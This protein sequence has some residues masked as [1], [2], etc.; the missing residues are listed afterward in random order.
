MKNLLL[1]F[2]V[3]F[4][5]SLFSQK[6]QTTPL[7][8]DNSA[9][10]K[11]VFQKYT[12]ESRTNY[13]ESKFPLLKVNDKYL[14]NHNTGIDKVTFENYLSNCPQS[15][16][17]ANLG[18]KSYSKARKLST[19][20]TLSSFA[21]LLGAGYLGYKGY[22]TENTNFY[23]F[24]GGLVLG[25]LATS[26][27]YNR[28]ADK[29][30]AKANEQIISAFDI[31]D[32]T[33]FKPIDN[34]NLTPEK[35]DTYLVEGT[36][37]NETKNGEFNDKEKVKIEVIEDNVDKSFLGLSVGTGAHIINTINIPLAGEIF[38]YKNGFY[39][40]VH[41]MYS[42]FNQSEYFN[43]IGTPTNYNLGVD[44]TLPFSKKISHKKLP[45]NL[46]QAY[47]LDFSGILDLKVLN[48]FGIDIG[49]DYYQNAMS[50]SD[51]EYIFLENGQKINASNLLNKSVFL[52]FG[53]S[54]S[55]FNNVVYK[56]DDNRFEKDVKTQ[57]ALFRLYINGLYNVRPSYVNFI[58]NAEVSPLNLKKLGGNIGIDAK[59]IKKSIGILY[60]LE[61]GLYP[62]IEGLTTLGGNFGL[63]LLFAK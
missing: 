60:N 34:D 12:I 46:G 43:E 50:F 9:K 49:I 54:Y 3:F 18:L 59:M 7:N 38:Y 53:P 27:I 17:M 56:V 22:D 21:L 11:I 42:L 6:T 45:V 58:K 63:G 2:F 1:L 51:D 25:G 47:G 31:Y 62:T 26:F 55:F 8:V 28:L 20:G 5:F 35:W 23:Y 33:C 52:K 37:D 4:A 24:G 44:F 32:K 14:D 39:F 10:L 29:K 61:F 36:E 13:I 48:T 16:S 41:G 57:K 15:L 40:D 30:I 19:G